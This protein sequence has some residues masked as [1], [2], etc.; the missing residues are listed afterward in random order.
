MSEK[1]MKILV[2]NG[3]IPQL[4]YVDLQLYESCILGKQKRFSFSKS[5]KDLKEDKSELIHTSVWEPATVS[6]LRGSNYYVTFIN[7]FIGRYG[8]IL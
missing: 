2:S 4:K 7:D 5:G 8:F 1:G 3:K 6:S